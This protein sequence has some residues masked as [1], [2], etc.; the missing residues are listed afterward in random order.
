MHEAAKLLPG[1][2]VET[3]D[4]RDAESTACLLP[5]CKR[6]QTV[7]FIGSSGVGKST[8]INTLT[9]EGR[10]ETQAIRSDDDKGRHTTTGRALHRL[11]MGG[12]LMDTPGMRELQLTDAASGLDSVFADVTALARSCRFSDCR[13]ES[14]PGCAVTAA[15][16]EGRSIL[17]ASG[18]GASSPPRKPITMKASPSDAPAAGLSEGFRKTSS[19]RSASSGSFES[20][21]RPT[22]SSR[23]ATLSR[24]H[25]S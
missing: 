25:I 5:W 7:A 18:A 11:A 21:V 12:W 10:I 15:L 14:E 6:G 3:V 4:G 13:H 8:L 17:T 1:L 2:L 20:S 16:A 9:G 24:A 22:P 23:L 19:R